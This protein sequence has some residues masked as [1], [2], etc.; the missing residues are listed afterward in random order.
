MGWIGKALISFQ[1]S[2]GSNELSKVA[3][4]QPMHAVTLRLCCDVVPRL[5]KL[6]KLLGKQ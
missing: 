3:A 5:A 6:L 2:S 1:Q 4:G